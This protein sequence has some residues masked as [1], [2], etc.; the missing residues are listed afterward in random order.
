MFFRR[1]VI[2]QRVRLKR[3]ET[4]LGRYTGKR[5]STELGP[6]TFS[7][8]AYDRKTGDFGVAVQSKFIAVGAVVPWAKAKVGAVAT[9]ASAN[10]SYGP[11]AL[12]MLQR[13]LTS[14]QALER[15]L[16]EDKQSQVR[17][18][19]IVDS[20]GNVA[21]HT[22]TE[23]MDWAGHVTGDCFSCQGNILV[24]KE[25]VDSMAEAYARTNGDLIDRL[26]AALAA[27]QMAGGDRRGQQSA[28]LLIVREG[29]GYEGFTDRYVDLRVDDSPHPI[30]ELKRIVNLYDMTMLS[31]EAA[32]NLI[33]IAGPVARSIQRSLKAL[34]FYRGSV[35]GIYDEATK[36]ALRDFVNVNNF[37]N[38]MHHDGLI[39]NS[40]LQYM[41]HSAKVDQHQKANRKR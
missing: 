38:R 36:K 40:I 7:I 24:S 19:A 32:S 41:Q 31:R 12:D 5:S 8:V 37:E 21:V 26:L 17:Q 10:V 16:A 27:G 2:D 28:A 23:C 39:W 29:G 20:E 34:S 14:A 1:L 22:G 25:V 33:P 15:L 6:S 18:A 9:Q 13:G 35:T 3:A 11:R 30:N 4:Q